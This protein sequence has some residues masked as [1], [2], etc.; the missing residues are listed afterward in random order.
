MSSAKETRQWLDQ[1][2][3]PVTA[4]LRR[5]LALPRPD[6]M[7]MFDFELSRGAV[8]DTFPVSVFMMDNSAGQVETDYLAIELPEGSPKPPEEIDAQVL[9][10]WFINRWR[11][12]GGPAS[13][14]RGYIGHHDDIE[15]VDLNTGKTIDSEEKWDG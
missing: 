13:G 6:E 7:E 15:S 2:A 10:K 1:V 12:A 3:A 9:F 4:E 8:P 11:D 14:T 5:L